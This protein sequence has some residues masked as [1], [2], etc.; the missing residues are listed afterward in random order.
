MPI[1]GHEPLNDAVSQILKEH[2]FDPGDV[3]GL[4]GAIRCRPG[5]E[6]TSSTIQ[7][8]IIA[9]ESEGGEWILQEEVGL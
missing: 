6:A 8:I 3:E 2:R 7:A 5:Y 1:A 9:L 4:L